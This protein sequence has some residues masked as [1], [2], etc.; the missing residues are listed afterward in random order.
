[1]RK[2]VYLEQ[3]APMIGGYHR[4]HDEDSNVPPID[5]IHED[6]FIKV[7]VEKGEIIEVDCSCDSEYMLAAMDRV[8]KAIRL[9]FHWI[10][11]EVLCYLNMDNAGGH[12][13]KLIVAEYT[14]LLK[15]KYNI[16]IIHQVPRS[17]YTNLLDL[18]VWCS[19]QSHV[20][21]EHYMKR[22]DIHALVGS[23][24]RAWRNAS[25]TEAIGRVWGRLRNVLVLIQKDEGGN[26][27]V[28]TMRGK[29][30]RNLDLPADFFDTISSTP[31]TNVA[32]T[33][34][35]TYLDLE[36][37]DSDDEEEELFMPS[38]LRARSL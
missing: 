2:N 6:I 32:I 27:L 30:F 15:E 35:T 16:V 23:V 4:R 10:P 36:D 26:N 5:V 28:E 22:T 7:R 25:I 21:K 1:L 18:G 8:G 13:T 14:K 34:V 20:E 12:G 11:K 31:T 17:P 37:D 38:N 9:A 33:P 3:D 24:G 29:K 19:L